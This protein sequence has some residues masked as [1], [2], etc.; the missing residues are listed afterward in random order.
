[1]LKYQTCSFLNEC[2]HNSKLPIVSCPVKSCSTLQHQIMIDGKASSVTIHHTSFS[3]QPLLNPIHLSTLY[4]LQKVTCEGESVQ[5]YSMASNDNTNKSYYDGDR[6]TSMMYSWRTGSFLLG[7]KWSGSSKS[8]I[9][10]ESSLSRWS[11]VLFLPFLNGIVHNNTTRYIFTPFCRGKHSRTDIF[12]DLRLQ[13]SKH[14]SIIRATRHAGAEIVFG[15]WNYCS[16]RGS[17]I[18]SKKAL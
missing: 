2:L 14:G 17:K 3:T 12:S 1:M 8:S 4:F 7:S 9:S 13:R 18:M 5:T 6:H 15:T 10:S 11:G 16:M